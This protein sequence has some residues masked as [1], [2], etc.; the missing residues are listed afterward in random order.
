MTK[1]EAQK[2]IAKLRL[3]IDKYRYSYHVLDK[4]LVSDAVLD[5]LK[6]ELFDLEQEFPE[7]VTPDSPTHRVGGSPLKSFRKVRHE[8]AMLSFN[9]AFSREDINDWIERLENYLKRKLT[10]I[11][12][13]CELKIDGLAIEL[14][15]ANGFL[16]EAST[17]GDGL[18]GEDVTQNI[19]T[20]EAVPLKLQTTHYKLPTRFVVRGEVFLSKK[21]FERIN[22]EQKK[23]GEKIYANPRNIA[24]GSIRQLD[25]QIT[26]SRRLDSFA[27]DI[28]TDVRQKIHSEEHEILHK[29]GFKTNPH[30]KLVHSL[31]EVFK[32]RDYW[33]KHREK[34]P[35]EIDGIVVQINDNKLFEE[36]SVVGKAPRAA[37]AYKFAAKEATTIVKNI[38]VQVGRTGAITPVAELQPVSVGGITISHATLHNYD[39]I[40]RLGLKIGDTVVVSRAGDVIPK[41]TMVL[42]KLRSGKEREF[43]MPG[44]CP[45]DGS[46]IVQDGVFHRCSNRAC[47]ARVMESIRHF[48][49]RKA[50]DIRGLGDKIINRFLD[51]GLIGDAADI[52]TLEEGDIEILER[53]GEKS[54][55]NLVREIKQ[56][57]EVDLPRFIYAL[58]ILH[59]G[60]ET[61][62][63]LAR[64][65]KFKISNLKLKISDFVEKFNQESIEELQRIQDVGPKVA[66]SIHSWFKDPHNIALLK[67]L[68]RVGVTITVPKAAAKSQKLA[69][70]TFVLTGTLES[71]ARDEAKEKIRAQGGDVS[72]SVSK[73]TSYIVVGTDPGSKADKAEKLGV[74]ILSEKEF[75]DLL[76]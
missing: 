51:E 25:P 71:M 3:E 13:Y 54:A 32:F 28:V 8:V 66:E 44:S 41:I 46:K 24:A 63:L 17:R 4:S 36:L 31:E 50:F 57:K 64:N 65:L 75:I 68:E 53:F 55:Q 15:Y 22:K 20:I 59:I 72:E 26:A 56:K 11:D 7:L 52:F 67:K 48:V 16:V 74:K 70:K 18:V 23:K 34:I 45:V 1:S 6:K 30:N 39:E 37:V 29:L 62:A 47:G 35:Y 33:E 40:K 43:K 76:S 12:F 19:R 42:P 5:S 9:D 69:G 49:S 21:E 27:Y 14:V 73:K 60:E 2:R 58:G 61:A 10:N 38:K